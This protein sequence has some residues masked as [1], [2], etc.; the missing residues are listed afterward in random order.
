[1]FVVSNSLRLRRVSAVSVQ[2]T[3]RTVTNPGRTAPP[4]PARTP[5]P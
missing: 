1:V 5:P 2:T 3:R 4:T